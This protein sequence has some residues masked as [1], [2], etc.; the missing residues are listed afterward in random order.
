M[1][2]G[3]K[4]TLMMQFHPEKTADGLKMIGNWLD[5]KRN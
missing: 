3:V 4:N 1:I 2:A 5:E